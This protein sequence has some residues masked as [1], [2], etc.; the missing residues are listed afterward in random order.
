VA[1]AHEDEGS[2]E[3]DDDDDGKGVS[4]EAAARKEVARAQ[5]WAEGLTRDHLMWYLEEF[6]SSAY[7]D[8]VAAFAPENAKE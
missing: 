8:W 7:E 6:P 2:G 1:N 5:A 4:S 3:A